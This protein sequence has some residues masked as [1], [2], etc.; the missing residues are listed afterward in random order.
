MT[1]KVITDSTSDIPAELARKLDIMVVPVCVRFAETVYRDGADIGKEEF[2]SK[3]TT[4]PDHP[5]T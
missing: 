4:S 1:V 2:Y 3:L 5:V